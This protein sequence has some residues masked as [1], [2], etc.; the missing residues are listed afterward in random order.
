M[1]VAEGRGGI[2]PG[3]AWNDTGNWGEGRGGNG[4]CAGVA[5]AKRGRS[6]AFY[7]HLHEPAV[8]WAALW[9]PIKTLHAFFG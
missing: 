2:E 1:V 3:T 4:G 7:L 9:L 6:P 5:S 8:A